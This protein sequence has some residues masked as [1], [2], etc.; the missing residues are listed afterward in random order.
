MAKGT[1]GS[2]SRALVWVILALLIVGLAGFGATN[3]GGSVR[4][5]ATVGD[6]EIDVNEYG[7]ELQQELRALAAQS[8]RAF[9]MAE[10][11]ALGLDAA[12]LSRLVNR[13]ALD[14]E[15]ARLGLS[16][17][18]ETVRDQ[19]TQIPA[20]QGLDGGF[21]REAYAFT[22]D[23]AGLTIAEFEER[24]R[25]ESARNILQASVV[26]G[27][28]VPAVYTD[29][30]YAWAREERDITWALIDADTLDVPLP[31]PS[32][33][34]LEAFHAENAEDFT[35]SETKA[36]TYAWLTPDMILDTIAVDEDALREAYDARSDEFNQPERRLVERLVFA[37][38]AAAEAARAR[39]DA[40]ETTFADLVAERDLTLADIDMGDVTPDELGAAGEAVF[41]LDEPGVA[42]P[43]PSPLGPALYRVNAI[44]AAS[45][46][47][48][49]DAR[50]ELEAELASDRASRVIRDMREDIDD[51]L[52]GGATLEEIAEETEME[53][54][55]IDWRQDVEDGI[56]AYQEFRDAA[57]VAEEGDFPELYELEQG[58]LFALRVDEVRP[59]VL[60]PLTEVRPE[61]IAG[62][63][64][65]QTA[66]LAVDRAQEAQQAIE[67]GAE[68]AGLDLPLRTARGLMRNG[69]L[70]DAP[71][72][73]VE[74]VFQMGVDDVRVFEADGGAAIVRLDAV[75]VPA[76]DD[77]ETRE[78]KRQFS[79]AAAQ[80]L[81]GDALALFSRAIQ[82]RAGVSVNQQAINAVHAQ[83]Q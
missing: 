14:D 65:A 48:F 31:E 19:I 35:L 53:L 29:T 69:F 11:R 39:L 79:E 32:E 16:V 3:F 82:A 61:V 60:Q 4:A 77:A 38:D 34:D 81:A 21:D 18:D 12:V 2:V 51:L 42:G 56:A 26:N 5:V 13:A 50:T 75:T 15:T 68:M 80:G 20:F 23:N 8:G 47:S 41:A 1:K 71:A 78:I 49:E 76:G 63:E 40:G 28:Q 70:E 25:D 33:E 73:M 67:G 22:L 83:F 64:Q 66:R 62:W 74:N 37:D 59:P 44:L 7:R 46:T 54:G 10:A 30:L 9:S 72:G 58:G 55:R 45:E 6:E 36:I 52:A 43:L 17:G 27:I 24:V 57:L